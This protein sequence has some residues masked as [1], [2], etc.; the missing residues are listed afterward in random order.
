MHAALLSPMLHI[1][2]SSLLSKTAAYLYNPTASQALYAH[3][4]T[5]SIITAVLGGMLYGT[6]FWGSWTT[7]GEVERNEWEDLEGDTDVEG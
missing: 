5:G 6:E 7:R 3:I 1:N 2:Y 4:W